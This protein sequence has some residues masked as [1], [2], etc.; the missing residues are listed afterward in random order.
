[1]ILLERREQIL[2]QEIVRAVDQPAHRGADRV[3]RLG[4]TSAVHTGFLH[5]V[6]DLLHHAGHAH[7]EKLVDV[8]AEYRQEL[9]PLQQRIAAV[10]RFFE[11]PPLELQVAEFTIQIERG[12]VQFGE[13]REFE[14]RS[15][16]FR[17]HVFSSVPNWRELGG[18]AGFRYGVRAAGQ[19]K[20]SQKRA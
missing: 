14:R 8:G 4:R 13:I 16:G 17:T 7:H 15:G 10:A 12:I 2:A 11:N 20:A 5:A 18:A 3:Q 19:S 1:M 9:H 6:L